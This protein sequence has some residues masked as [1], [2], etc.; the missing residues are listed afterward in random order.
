M[1]VLSISEMESILGITDEDKTTCPF[2]GENGCDDCKKGLDQET[3]EELY[4]QWLI[5]QLT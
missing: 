4:E 2:E 5:E 1:K 3:C